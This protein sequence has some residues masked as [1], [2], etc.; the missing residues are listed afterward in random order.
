MMSNFKSYKRRVLKELTE[1][2]I[3]ALKK[4]GMLVEAEAK[5][6]SPEDNGDLRRSISNKVDEHK[7]KVM[8]GTNTEYAIF[9]ELGTSRHKAQ[10][11]LMPAVEEN[12]D[13]I[14]DIIKKSYKK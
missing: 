1:S 12:E 13:K 10:A 4:I 14:R 8:I 3:L 11:F 9:Q 7:G 6:R 2:Q 5:L